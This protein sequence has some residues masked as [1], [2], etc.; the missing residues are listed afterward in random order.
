MVRQLLESEALLPF[1]SFKSP[2]AMIFPVSLCAKAIFADTSVKSLVPSFGLC[3][4]GK[5]KKTQGICFKDSTN[6]F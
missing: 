2:P 4:F 1:F 5:E 3:E 6:H